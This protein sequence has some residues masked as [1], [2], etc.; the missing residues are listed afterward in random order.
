MRARRARRGAGLG[1]VLSL[2]FAAD[3]AGALPP[4]WTVRGERGQLVLFGSIHL[5]PRGVNWRP[6]A[7]DA[8]LVRAAALWFE[9][10]IDQKT[11]ETALRLADRRGRLAPGDSLWARLN[12][13]QR[14]SV[15]RAAASVDIAPAAL[16]PL[17]PWR[18]ELALSLAQD[19]RDGAL[20]AAGVE[21]QIQND[22]PPSA[23]RHA[24][25]RVEQQIGFLAGGAEGEQIA[26]LEETAREMTTDPDLYGRTVREW[27]AGDLAGLRRDDLDPLKT[28]APAA[29]RRLIV[30]RNRRWAPVLARL[31]RAPGVTV[32]VVGVGHLIGPE[33][34]P[35][36]LRARGLVVD[37][38]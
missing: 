35:A 3:G 38:P 25:E 2:I 12:P 7:L 22:A 13:G 1:L 29:Y 8:A 26:S 27:L 30:E 15:E 36:L 17:R 37:G 32:V 28:A 24:L 5:L 10:P 23:D 6:A 18:A 11:D 33:G 14:D 21:A 19:A 16:T 4:V 34:L 9:L 31:A 20:A